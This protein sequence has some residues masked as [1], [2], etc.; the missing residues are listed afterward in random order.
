LSSI[1]SLPFSRVCSTCRVECRLYRLFFLC[2]GEDQFHS[3]RK[4]DLLSGSRVPVRTLMLMQF[5]NSESLCCCHFSRELTTPSTP[6]CFDD[7]HPELSRGGAPQYWTWV[8]CSNKNSS[9][10]EFQIT[11]ARSSVTMRHVVWG[12]CLPAPSKSHYDV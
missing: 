2:V 9:I 1:F 3:R 12:S 5:Q 7:E 4:V 10:D 11:G 8:L 6:P